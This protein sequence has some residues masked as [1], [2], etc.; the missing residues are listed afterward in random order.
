MPNSRRAFQAIRDFVSVPNH[1]HVPRMVA[2][3][4]VCGSPSCVFPLSLVMMSPLAGGSVDY[5]TKPAALSTKRGVLVSLSPVILNN[6]WYARNSCVCVFASSAP[7]ST[8]FIVTVH[9]ARA[10]RPQQLATSGGVLQRR[11]AVGR[12]EFL[13]LGFHFAR[14]PAGRFA[15]ATGHTGCHSDRNV[16][17]W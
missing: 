15:R 4:G 11:G 17:Q 14:Q 12:R 5:P 10:C 2:C 1:D 3:C 6:A 9:V 13:P 16:F 7:A 8:H